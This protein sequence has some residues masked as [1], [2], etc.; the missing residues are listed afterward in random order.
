MAWFVL[1]KWYRTDGFIMQLPLGGDSVVTTDN[2]KAKDT[3]KAVLFHSRFVAV[4]CR[5]IFGRHGQIK[6]VP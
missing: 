2:H 4:R 1:V 5:T 3:T 6:G